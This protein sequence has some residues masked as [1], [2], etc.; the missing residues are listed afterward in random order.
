[1]KAIKKV[2]VA[3]RNFA[4]VPKNINQKNRLHMTQQGGLVQTQNKMKRQT[5]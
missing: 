5:H 4:N 2:R 1:M 3:L